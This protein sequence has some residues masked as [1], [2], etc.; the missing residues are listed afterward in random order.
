MNTCDKCEQEEESLRLV[1]LTSDDF[2]PKMNE[3]VPQKAY[4]KYD[5]LCEPCYLEVI[6]DNT[7]KNFCINELADIDEQEY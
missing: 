6:N 5:A 1:W 7:I 2:E 4:K 3:I